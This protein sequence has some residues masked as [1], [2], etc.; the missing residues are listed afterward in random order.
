MKATYN[1]SPY[2]KYS[3]TIIL[4]ANIWFHVPL[5]VCLTIKEC[6]HCLW[7]T[8]LCKPYGHVTH[9]Y[10]FEYLHR[11]FLVLSF[12]HSFPELCIK[13]TDSCFYDFIKSSCIFIIASWCWC[14][15]LYDFHFISVVWFDYQS[16]KLLTYTIESFNISC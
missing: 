1:F 5:L 10:P 13:V 2:P 4:V 15:N 3:S 11:S 8:L 16:Y 6:V 7:I 12:L 9:L 14:G